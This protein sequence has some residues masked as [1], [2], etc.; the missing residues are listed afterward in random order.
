M[1]PIFFLA[2]SVC[3]FH[4]DVTRRTL[5]LFPIFVVSSPFLPRNI[6]LSLLMAAT[7][8]YFDQSLHI[9]TYQQ[10]FNRIKGGPPN[11]P[12]LSLWDCLALIPKGQLRALSGFHPSAKSRAVSAMEVR[13]HGAFDAFFSVKGFS[14]RQWSVIPLAD[15]RSEIF[16][17]PTR[18]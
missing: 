6:W 9:I 17:Y 8:R 15:E 4:N 1:S 16:R 11:R 10:F 7:L 13:P 3:I 5:G 14:W 12:C 18:I 2:L